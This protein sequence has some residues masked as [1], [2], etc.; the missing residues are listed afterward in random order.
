VWQTASPTSSVVEFGPVST[1][2]TTAGDP[3]ASTTDHAVTITGLTAGASYGY[4][5]V[6]GSTAASP[7]FGF[8]TAPGA[9]TQPFTALVFGDSGLGTPDQMTLAQHMSQEKFDLVLHTGDVIYPNGAA[10]YYDARF[11]QP[12]AP[13]LTSRPI[14]PAIG[15]HDWS[16]QNGQ[17]YLDAFHLPKNNPQQTEL[18]YS[19]DWGN[20]HFVSID[21]WNTFRVAGPAMNWLAN[22]LA[23]TTRRWKVVYMH[24][25]LFSS[26]YHGDDTQLQNVLEPVLE[27]AEVDLVLAGHDHDYERMKPIKRFST[28]PNYPGIPFIVT[29][30]GGAELRPFKA[31]MHSETLKSEN[32]HHYL[33][34]TFRDSTIEGNAVRVDGSSI[35]TFT[36]QHH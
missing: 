20:T 15:N 21:T 19:F 24:V 13:I 33:L 34:L 31:N 22:D 12:Y 18:Y 30:G 1:L 14:F 32:G 36:I 35:E 11:F 29:G 3:N 28:D 26:G 8:S 7:T 16:S 5:I 2:G 9:T 23:A 10:S 27:R 6:Q 4:R 17:P 25:P